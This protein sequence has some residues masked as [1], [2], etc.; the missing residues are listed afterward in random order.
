MKKTR[1]LYIESNRDGTV[2]G[3]YYSLFYLIEGLN[4]HVYEPIVMFY[5]D[6]PLISMFEQ[7]A[8]KVIIFDHYSPSDNYINNI[9]D[10]IKFVPRF[11]RDILWGH[12]ELLKKL[13]EIKPDIVHF[14][15]SY[16]TN[17]D[18]ALA[19]KRRGIKL[20]AHDRGTRPPASL[21]TKFFVKYMDAVICVSDSYLKYVTE[22]N[23]KPKKAYRVY[24]GLDTTKLEGLCSPVQREFIRQEFNVDSNCFFIGMIGNIDYW[25]GQLVLAKSISLIIKKFS[26]IKVAIVGNTSAASKNYE[27]EIKNYISKN[28]LKERIFLTGY[29]NDI[30]ALLSAFD[31]FVHASIEPEPF[32]RVILEA[33]AMKKPIVATNSG[34]P[35]EILVNGESGLLVPMGDEHAMAKAISTYLNDMKHAEQI[36]INGWLRLKENFSIQKMVEG[37][38]AVYKE[39]LTQ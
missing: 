1:I 4:K 22:Q 33:M 10:L 21:Q 34:G 36:G 16:A 2:G 3:S 28:D 7:V 24:N 39:V 26:N 35:S 14:N 12:F 15:N 9:G 25:K 19:C 8:Q 23:L 27:N 11:V 6:N 31:I 17:H 5:E 37:V 18:W 20:I 29:R 38:E 32:G 13:D 30:P